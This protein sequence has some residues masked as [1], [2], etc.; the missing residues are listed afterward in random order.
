MQECTIIFFLIG[1]RLVIVYN[2]FVA[3]EKLSALILDIY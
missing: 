2:M 1:S 3:V